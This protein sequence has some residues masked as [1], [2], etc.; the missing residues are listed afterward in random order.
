MGPKKSDKAAAVKLTAE[1]R[2]VSRIASRVVLLLICVFTL[3][4]RSCTAS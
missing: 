1:E 2:K 3:A 4:S